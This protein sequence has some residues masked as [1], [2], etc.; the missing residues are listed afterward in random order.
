M[1][2]PK[3]QQKI[4]GTHGDENIR[5][6]NKWFYAIAFTNMSN[7]AKFLLAFKKHSAIHF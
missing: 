2:I 7:A 3:K 4:E 5:D 6:T 1:C